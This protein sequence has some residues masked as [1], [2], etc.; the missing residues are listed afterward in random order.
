MMRKLFTALSVAA[1]AATAL[2]TPASARSDL[3][4]NSRGG[5]L[6][7]GAAAGTVLGVGL[8]N[9]WFSADAATIP[10]FPATAA[11]AAV[12]GGVVGVGTIALIDASV[13]P[14]RGFHALFGLNHGACADGEYVGY[15]ARR[16]R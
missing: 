5:A 11:G 9:G 6:L 15:G 2:A 10:I 14:C 1:V 13:Q 8:Y 12:S 7:A 4:A 3:Y 16:M